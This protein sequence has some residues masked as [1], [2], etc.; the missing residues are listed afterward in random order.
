[1]ETK[2]IE[3]LD[4]IA[5]WIG[6]I[7]FPVIVFLVFGMIVLVSVFIVAFVSLVIMA[8]TDVYLDRKYPTG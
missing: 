3:T 7:T 6:V 2:N 1:M 4:C 5:I 8:I